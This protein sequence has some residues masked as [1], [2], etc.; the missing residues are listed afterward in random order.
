M[1]LYGTQALAS[2]DEFANSDKVLESFYV[3]NLLRLSDTDIK[4]FCESEEAKILVEKQVLKKPTMMRL[5]KADDEKRR[6]KLMAYQ[7]AKESNDPLW[8]KLKKYQKL[9]KDTINAIMKKYGNKAAR[10][11]K[12]AQKSYIKSATAVQKAAGTTDNNTK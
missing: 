6:T 9:R 4:K 7:L 5:S 1:S 2:L 8:E 12:I 11:S 10:M 3:D